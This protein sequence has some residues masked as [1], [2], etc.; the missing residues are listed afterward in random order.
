MT[1]GLAV[2]GILRPHGEY[3]DALVALT[4]ALIGVENIVVTLRRPNKLAV[5]TGLLLRER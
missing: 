1:L 2:T 5:A 4:I 3:I